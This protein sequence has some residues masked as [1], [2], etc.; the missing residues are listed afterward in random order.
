MQTN[1]LFV[2]TFITGLFFCSYSTA[3]LKNGQHN[4]FLVDWSPLAAVPCYASA[5]HNMR[6]AGRCTAHLMEFLRMSGVPT[7]HTTCVGHSLGAHV[8]G[9]TS[10]FLNFRMNKIIGT[11][12]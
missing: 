3:Y 8:C 6:A 11:Y 12:M 1:N 5:V 10:N 7:E 4:V 2:D 9:I